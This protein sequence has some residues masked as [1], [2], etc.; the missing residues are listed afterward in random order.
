MISV[1]CPAI[2]RLYLVGSEEAL[3]SGTIPVTRVATDDDD[4][5]DIDDAVMTDTDEEVTKV[6]DCD[7]DRVEET[8]A[9]DEDNAVDIGTPLSL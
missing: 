1:C 8:L 4:A 9:N 7:D 6:V 5:N 3:A 2:A